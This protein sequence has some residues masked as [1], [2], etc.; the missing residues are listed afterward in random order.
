VFV[1]TPILLTE[2]RARARLNDDQAGRVVYLRDAIERLCDPKFGHGAGTLAASVEQQAVEVEFG[3]GATALAAEVG[4]YGIE[5]APEVA[6][7]AL[8]AFGVHSTHRLCTAAQLATTTNGVIL[9]G[10]SPYLYFVLAGEVALDVRVSGR[11]PSRSTGPV[12]GSSSGGRP[13]WAAAP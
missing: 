11:E 12:R 1:D 4:E 3:P 8:Q 6:P 9:G 10:D 5:E 2:D 7:E 13:R